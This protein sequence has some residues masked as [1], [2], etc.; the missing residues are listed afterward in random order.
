MPTGVKKHMDVGFKGFDT[1]HP[2]N[3]V[4]MPSANP[5]LTI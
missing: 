2:G 3:T 4:S 5:A 1:Q